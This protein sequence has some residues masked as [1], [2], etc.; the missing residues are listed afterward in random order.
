M[1]TI[2]RFRSRHE[3]LALI[4]PGGPTPPDDCVV[5]FEDDFDRPNG[6]PGP[7]WEVTPQFPSF[8]AVIQDQRLVPDGVAGFVRTAGLE[9]GAVTAT[10]Q[11]FVLSGAGN[12]IQLSAAYDFDSNSGYRAGVTNNDTLLSLTLLRVDAGSS[13]TILPTIPVSPI[14]L[15]GFLLAIDLTDPDDIVVAF[16]DQRF[17]VSDSTYRLGEIGLF[18]QSSASFADISVCAP[19]A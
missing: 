12:A 7:P 3:S 9:F 8:P 2:S 1:S 14:S 6:P 4:G 18:V 13:T 5:V 15:D 16:N 17:M 19:A 10:T 11:A